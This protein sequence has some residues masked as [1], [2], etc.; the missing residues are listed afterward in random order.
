MKAGLPSGFQSMPYRRTVPGNCVRTT[1]TRQ[2]TDPDLALL[3][4]MAGD[5]TVM[6]PSRDAGD[7]SLSVVGSRAC[8]TGEGYVSLDVGAEPIGADVSSTIATG[9]RDHVGLVLR[10][11]KRRTG[12]L[13][14]ASSVF[15]CIALARAPDEVLL[16]EFDDVAEGTAAAARTKCSDHLD[17]ES[18]KYFALSDAEPITLHRAGNASSCTSGGLVNATSNA[19]PEWARGLTRMSMSAGGGGASDP[20]SA[21][22]DSSA[23]H[24][25]VA[26]HD[27]ESNR[28][29]P[30]NI[31]VLW[32]AR[33]AH[34]AV[35]LAVVH[36]PDDSIQ[37]WAT[38]FSG[39]SNGTAVAYAIESSSGEASFDSVASARARCTAAMA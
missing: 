30:A 32:A 8:V 25:P 2:P 4:A 24:L 31:D 14:A 37:C 39:A 12:S 29:A 5:Y 6:H 28:S 16:F 22:V 18:S 13:E 26:L 34:P 10:H 7:A 38:L 20:S 19:F 1:V 17:G 36:H 35:R 21:C 9:Q 3:E 23:I 27:T 33:T 11:D 15:R